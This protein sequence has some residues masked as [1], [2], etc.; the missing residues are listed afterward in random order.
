MIDSFQ[1]EYRFLSNFYLVKVGMDGEIYPSVENAYQ[2]AKSFKTN[3]SPAFLSCTPGQAKRLG[4]HVPIDGH[5]E[6]VKLRVMLSLLWSKF[7]DPELKEKLLSTGNKKLVEG[8]NWG[9]TFW[10]VCE[11]KGSNHLGNLLMQVRRELARNEL[12]RNTNVTVKPD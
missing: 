10:G 2:A 7:S 8:N 3:R 9:D 11:G 1:D 6:K 12:Y 5:W 4:K